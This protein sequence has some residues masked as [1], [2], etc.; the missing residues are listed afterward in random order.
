MDG[1]LPALEG[2]AAHSDAV[3]SGGNVPAP[4]PAPAALQNDSGLASNNF[5][6]SSEA[7]NRFVDD[8]SRSMG[9][10][11][12][13]N[14]TPVAPAG[15]AP[16]IEDNAV[17]VPLPPAPVGGDRTV[18]PAPRI[19][20]PVVNNDDL[21]HESP[22]ANPTSAEAVPA[23]GWGYS[24]QAGDNIWKISSKVYG[25][26]KFT[27]KIVDA[28]KDVN[29]QKLKPGMVLKVPSLPNKTLLVKLPS[30]ADAKAGRSAN[31]SAPSN[32]LQP[33][34]ASRGV[35]APVDR[36]GGISTET[37]L[38][39]VEQKHTVQAGETLGNIAQK[40]YGASGPK[41]VGRILA[42]NK[43]VDPAKLKIGQELVIPAK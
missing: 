16:V 3:E 38:P 12:V 19:N 36:T 35:T 18:T 17:I 14:P 7:L 2:A 11:P 21:D 10:A 41:S 33:V 31:P 1:S 26:G 25:D 8:Q 34:P 43:S 6:P 28:N 24:V 39:G 40:Y 30:Y 42:A 22:H 15:R 4:A 29:V 23:D 32:N 13:V 27:Q 5:G 20:P 9:G 37:A